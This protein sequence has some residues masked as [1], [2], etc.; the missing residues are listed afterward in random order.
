MSRTIPPTR[1]SLQDSVQT[2]TPPKSKTLTDQTNELFAAVTSMTDNGMASIKQKLWHSEIP[3]HNPIFD[4]DIETLSFTQKDIVYI[5]YYDEE[6]FQ[7]LKANLRAKGC[8]TNSY[9]KENLHFYVKYVKDSRAKRI[10]RERRGTTP[11]NAAA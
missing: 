1:L 7:M 3:D 5:A 10:Q 2:Q 6:A 8:V 4:K 9:L 11:S